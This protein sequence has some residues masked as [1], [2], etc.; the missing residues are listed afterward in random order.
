MV[1]FLTIAQAK[2]HKKGNIRFTVTSLGEISSGTGTKGSWEKQLV[3]IK[4]E[5]DSMTLTLWND[6]I[7]N[8]ENGKRYALSNA[9]WS[10]YKGEPQLTLGKYADLKEIGE[11]TKSIPPAI[12]AGIPQ[13]TIP[14]NVPHNLTND[15]MIPRIYAMTAEMYQDFTD[16]KQKE[17]KTQ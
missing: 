3:T 14:E 11:I 6:D 9:W 10:E 1:E 2:M 12:A 13:T 8:A 15:E 17:S 5:T 4:D 7:G 16:R